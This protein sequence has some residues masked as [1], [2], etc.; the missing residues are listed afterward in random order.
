M[1]AQKHTMGCGVASV[2]NVLG[3]SYNRALYLFDN[4]KENVKD[5]GFL[6]KDIVAALNKSGKNYHYGYINQTI[7]KKIYNPGTIVFIRRSK[8]YPY[9]HYLTRSNN[10]WVDPWINL[11]YDKEPRHSIAGIRERL[12]GKAIYAILTV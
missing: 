7:R 6:C 2:A 4:G 3:I 5:T 1:I 8:R 12:L 9:G 11:R 10:R